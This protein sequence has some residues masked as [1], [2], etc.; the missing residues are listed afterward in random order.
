MTSES[1][2]EINSAS[3]LALPEGSEN[4]VVYC[5]AS[6]KGLGAV[7]MQKEKVIAYA[8]R[9]LKIHW[10]KNYMTH[11]LELGAVVFAPRC[12][13]EYALRY[14]SLRREKKEFE[15]VNTKMDYHGLV[16]ESFD[17]ARSVALREDLMEKLTRQYLKEVDFSGERSASFRSS[18]NRDEVLIDEPLAILWTKS[19]LMEKPNSLKEP[20]EIMDRDVKLSY[21]ISSD[22]SDESGDH[23]PSRVILFGDIPTVIPS[24]L[25]VAPET[26]TI[27]PVISSAAPVMEIDFTRAHFLLPSDFTIHMHR[28]FEAHA[29]LIVHHYRTLMLYH[30]LVWGTGVTARPSSSHEFPIAP[31]ITGSSGICRRSATL[32]RP[33]EAI[34]FGRPYHTHLNRPRKLLTAR[35]RVGPLPARILASRHASPRSLDHHLSS[36]SS[37]SDSSPVHSLGLD[38]PDQAHSGSSTRD[39]S[40][41]LCYPTRRAP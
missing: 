25:V 10:K 36:S 1:S 16:I 22:S 26:S 19:T 38:A 3:I 33:G 2:R 30:W 21:H 27:A 31:V 34:P 23:R 20:V 4:F 14:Q 37:S 29:L 39:L 8:S 7:L 15:T 24:T 40:P 35:K 32:I 6:H 13:D 12:G 5:D 11:D 41:R 17:Y 28:F 9:Q 18:L